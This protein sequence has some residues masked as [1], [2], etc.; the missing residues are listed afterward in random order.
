MGRGRW[1]LLL[2][3]AVLTMVAWGQ[4]FSGESVVTDPTL[5]SPPLSSAASGPQSVEGRQLADSLASFK[6]IAGPFLKQHCIGCH[7]AVDLE[8]GIRVDQLD[9]QLPESSLKLWGEIAEQIESTE[10]PP[11]EEQQPSEASRDRMLRWIEQA[12]D[13]ARSRKQPID[14]AVRRLTVDQYRNTLRDLLGLDEDFAAVLPPDGVSRHGFTND[15]TTLLTSPLQVES[16]FAIA[17]K[18]MEA[19]LVNDTEP[20]RIQNFRMDLGRSINP[21][22]FGESLILGANSRLLANQDFVVKELTP[23]KPFNFYPLRMRTKY[24]FNEGY[25]GNGTVRGW[26]Q[27]DS[28][29]HSVFACVRGDGGYPLGEAY[30]TVPSGLLLRPS[31]PTT[32]IFGQ[33]S[34]YGPKANF[35]IALRELPE[36]GRFRV[37]VQAAKYDD[38]LLLVGRGYQSVDPPEQTSRVSQQ[39]ITSQQILV[40]VD[41]LPA[42]IKIAREPLGLVSPI[43]SVSSRRVTPEK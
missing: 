1:L 25:Q 31:I 42:P 13:R 8:S 14:G 26:R 30:R 27:Y 23:A 35:K 22:P 21:Q 28:I 15:M 18:A 11:E 39:P 36:F 32:E 6:V 43:R 24:R 19:C 7:N 9:G 17:E 5:E 10:M 41:Q 12:M 37:T 2:G 3:F 20:P 40:P 38:G 34:T 33:S 16:W 29:Y 4:D